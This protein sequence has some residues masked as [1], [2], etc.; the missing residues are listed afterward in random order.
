MCTRKIFYSNFHLRR[1]GK[2]SLDIKIYEK[3]KKIEN[4]NFDIFPF[5]YFIG[6][7]EQKNFVPN[8]VTVLS[9][10]FCL[11]PRTFL[12]SIVF[13]VWS[14]I[15]KSKKRPILA[16]WKGRKAPISAI[17]FLTFAQMGTISIEK[18]VCRTFNL[19]RRCSICFL[20]CL[21]NFVQ[22]A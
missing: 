15:Q 18:C 22:S 21:L 6:F 20:F 8:K 19:F 7:S 1:N 3:K 9:I 14:K 11:A 10:R 16:L 17:H 12:L 2:W 4:R 13:F 5:C